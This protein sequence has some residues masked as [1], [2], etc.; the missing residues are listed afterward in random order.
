MRTRSS[1]VPLTTTIWLLV[2]LSS[3]LAGSAAGQTFIDPVEDLDS[4]RPEAWSMRYFTSISLLTGLG[5]PEERSPGS[6]ELAFEGSWVPSLSETERRVGFD[7]RKVEDLNKT[8]VF[9]RLRA[10][11]GLPNKFSLDLAWAPPVEVGGVESNL[12]SAAIGRPFGSRGDWRFGWRLYAQT[13]TV[14]GD[15]TCDENTVAAGNDPQRNPFQCREVSNDEGTMDYAG[16]E[17]STARRSES[18]FEPHFAVA[19]NYLDME[20]QVDAVYFNLIDRTKLRADDTT[21]SLTAGLGF[22]ASD[23]WRLAGELFYS[24]LGDVSRRVSP[25]SDEFR[26]DS[27][28]IFHVRGLIAYRVR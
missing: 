16:F 11:I 2:V 28:D 23:K 25:A 1:F 14:E 8:H 4:E 27:E 26:T 13:G 24:P 7:G 12:V 22:R 19:V 3:G 9:G 5:S 20:F 21:V 15:F 17:V 6:V 18:R 10:T